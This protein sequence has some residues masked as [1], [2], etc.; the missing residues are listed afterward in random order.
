MHRDIKP[1][2]ILINSVGFA[3]IADFGISRAM[4]GTRSFATSFVGTKLTAFTLLTL[5]T[6]N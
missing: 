1:G 6:C 2:N 3:K 4:D 5:N